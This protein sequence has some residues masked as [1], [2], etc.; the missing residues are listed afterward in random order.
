VNLNQLRIFFESAKQL[1][2]SKA[3]K[4]LYISQ[5]AVSSQIKH[6]EEM[7]KQQLFTKV[8][9]RIYLT[10]S[11]KVLLGYA[12]KIFELEA[13][14]EKTLNEIKEIQKGT[15]HVGTT[16]TYARY[17]MP[18]YISTFHAMYPGISIHLSEG[19]SM[20]MVQSLSNMKNEIAIVASANYP[21]SSNNIILGH[22]EILLVVRSD[23]EL[24]R[25]DS[26]TVEELSK[27]PLIMREEGSG[28]RRVIM[29][30]FRKA[31]CTPTILHEASNFG[32]IVELMEIGEGASFVVK[33]AVE[34]ELEQG[35]LK[36]I[37]II[38]ALL[39]MNVNIV[40]LSEKTLSKVGRAFINML[41]SSNSNKTVQ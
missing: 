22:E 41:L 23:H 11:G 24:A 16:K 2:F 17:L 10:E 31:N 39:T 3:A 25:R 30:M 26:I 15:L 18:K 5:P 35:I 14:A 4:R 27:I 9:R 37:K 21:K 8:G 13:E 7:F 29:D 33:S 36:A 32:L 6:L 1:S 34:K 28:A 19:S 20:E 38:D 12:S 40:Y